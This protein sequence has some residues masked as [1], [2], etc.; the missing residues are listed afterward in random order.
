MALLLRLNLTSD[1][2]KMPGLLGVFAGRLGVEGN[3]P[4]PASRLIIDIA[5]A[6]TA[7]ISARVAIRLLTRVALAL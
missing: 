1:G 7:A 4:L 6:T 3:S 2:D 5:I